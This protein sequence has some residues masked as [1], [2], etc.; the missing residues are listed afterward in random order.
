MKL[1]NSGNTPIFWAGGSQIKI[2]SDGI[3]ITTNGKFEVKAAE[4]QFMAGAQAGIN[5]TGFP[6]SK[7]YNEKFQMFLPS[8]EL[9]T[10]YDYKL[11]SD[12]GEYFSSTDEQGLT[13]EIHTENEEDLTLEMVWL[14]FEMNEDDASE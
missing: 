4:H 9:L 10:D 14:E 5:I 7:R 13:R 6:S 8:G 11:S 12:K 3:F 1:I 2:N